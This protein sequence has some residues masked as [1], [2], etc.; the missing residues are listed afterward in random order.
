MSLAAVLAF[1]VWHAGAGAQPDAGSRALAHATPA[2]TTGTWRGTALPCANHPTGS[3][4]PAPQ[5]ARSLAAVTVAPPPRGGTLDRRDLT[6]AAGPWAVVVR[7]LDGSLG[8]HG[9]VVTFPAETAGAG[10]PV[11][12]GGAHGLASTGELTWAVAGAHARVR[13]DLGEPAL[14]AIAAGTRVV[15]HRPSVRP[16]AGFR[17]ISTGPYRSPHVREVRYDGSQLDDTGTLHGLLYTGVVGEG[18]F[19]DQ[20]YRASVVSCGTV[21]GQPAVLSAVSGGNG[22]LA[23]QAAPG[24]VAYVGYSGDYLIGDVL[25]TVQRLANNSR[26]LDTRQWQATEPQVIDERNDP[27]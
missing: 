14:V 8:R 6:A 23:W 27:G 4:A 25:R 5:P 7:R 22:T 1:A 21:H 16:P 11:T 20:L 3:V 2:P 26:T 15:A 24:L 19:E 12:V 13:G 17:V 10:Q 18:G 9:A